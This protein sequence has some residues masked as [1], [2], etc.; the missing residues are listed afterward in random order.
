MTRWMKLLLGVAVALLLT[1]LIVSISDAALAAAWTVAL[2]LGVIAMGM[3]MIS[4]VIRK[5]VARFEEEERR[6]REA[7]RA[8]AP[9]APVPGQADHRTEAEHAEHELNHA[10]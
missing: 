3:F 1:G 4:W 7:A 5:E 6:K 2:P 10:H 9:Q 8:H